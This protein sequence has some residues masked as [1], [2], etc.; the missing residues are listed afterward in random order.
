MKITNFKNIDKKTF[1]AIR[2][3]IAT[4]L[5]SVGKEYGVQFKA[6]NISY[7][8]TY[9]NIKVSA[10]VIGEGGDVITQEAEAFQKLAHLFGLLSSDLFRAFVFRGTAYKIIGLNARAA[11][12]PI[13]L[14][15]M[16]TGKQARAGVD[17][18]KHNL[19]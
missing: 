11:K 5:D 15:N 9:F 12:N 16:N 13:M 4:A 6:G 19:K 3:S 8:D 14:L 2:K 1:D 10:H 7:S 18:V 17:F